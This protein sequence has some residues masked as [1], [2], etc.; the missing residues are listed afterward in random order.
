MYKVLYILIEGADDGR[1]FNRIVK[2]LFEGKYDYVGIW[3][4]AQKI[5]KQTRNF[6]RSIKAMSGHYIFVTDIDNSPCVTHRKDAKRQKLE[7][8]DKDRIVVVK[9]EIESWYLAG[10]DETC[11]RKCRI[12]HFNMTDN[13]TKEQFDNLIPRKFESSRIDFLKEILK[14]HQVEIAKQKNKS[15]RYFLEKHRY[16]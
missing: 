8:L 6:V 14:Y 12:P 2:P 5:P 13:I 1:F 9:R 4:H 15:F 7:N 16:N 11:C 3:E 10:L